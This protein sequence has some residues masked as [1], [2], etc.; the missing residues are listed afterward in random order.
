MPIVKCKKC[1]NVFLDTSNPCSTCGCSDVELYIKPQTAQTAHDVTPAGRTV[2]QR[3]FPSTVSIQ[4]AVMSRSFSTFFDHIFVFVGLCFLAQIPGAAVNILL[5]NLGI[6]GRIIATVISFIFAL[7]IQGAITYGV[8][9]VLRGHAAEFGESLVSGMAHFGPLALGG[10]A[11]IATFILE[12]SLGAMML[13]SDILIIVGSMAGILLVA[14]PMFLLLI[15]LTAAALLWHQLV[16][17]LPAYVVIYDV[18][19]DLGMI[20]I[21]ALVTF[22][23]G[24]IFLVYKSPCLRWAVFVPACVVEDLGPIESLKRS[25]ELVDGFS[26]N[27][28]IPDIW[29]LGST[30]ILGLNWKYLIGAICFIV[31]GYVAMVLIVFATGSY[32]IFETVVMVSTIESNSIFE[33]VFRMLIIAIPMAFGYVMIAVTYYELRNAREEVTYY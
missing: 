16:A 24:A 18:V 33:A 15:S 19:I 6:G 4:P 3:A 2:K 9:G 14:L 27:P 28:N 20:H 29:Y 21:I 17:F 23:S 26:V 22:V 11:L 5:W 1:R 8:Y 7:I 32:S 30:D 25:S 13:D 31:F 10:L 12:V